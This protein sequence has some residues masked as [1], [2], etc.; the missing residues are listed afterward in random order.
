M[1]KPVEDMTELEFMAYMADQLEAQIAPEML[2]FAEETL[3][4]APR[5]SGWSAELLAGAVDVLPDW[6]RDDCVGL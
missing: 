5:S 6:Q 2:I 1:G 3:M 4:F